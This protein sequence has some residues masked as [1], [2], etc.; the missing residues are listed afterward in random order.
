V[1]HEYLIQR[2]FLVTKTSNIPSLRKLISRQLV[3]YTNNV[4]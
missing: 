4:G 3:V 1:M 2:G